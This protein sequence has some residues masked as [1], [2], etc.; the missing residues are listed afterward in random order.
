[1]LRRMRS[2]AFLRFI[3]AMGASYRLELATRGSNTAHMPE[4]TPARS[5]KRQLAITLGAVAV[6]AIVIAAVVLRSGG[7]S[8]SSS[9]QPALTQIY[10]VSDP[11]G[12]TVA[13]T[14]GGVFGI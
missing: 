6:V 12:A 2:S 1:M 5:A 9:S 3:P 14:D 7:P 11:P 13:R 8:E 10:I 4:P